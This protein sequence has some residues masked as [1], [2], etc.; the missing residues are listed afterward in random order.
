MKILVLGGTVFVGRHIVEK[1]LLLGHEVT[2]FHRGQSG[3]NLPGVSHILGNRDGG[4]D[5]LGNERWDWV[6]DTCGYVPRIV[7]QSC[8][9]LKDRGDRYLFISTISVYA[10]FVEPGLT[11]TSPL[12]TLA[13]DTVEEITGET[14]GGLKVLCEEVVTRS[15][16]ERGLIVRPGMIVGPYD[17]TDRFTF[18]FQRASKGGKMISLC[19]R[20]EPVQFIDG[21]DLAD[22]CMH[23]LGVNQVGVYNATGPEFTMTWGDVFDEA[24]LQAGV[25]YEIVRPAMEWLKEKGVDSL[26]AQYPSE[27]GLAGLYQVNVV[28]GIAAGL[29]YLPLADSVGD[30]IAWRQMVS[31]PL[32]VGLSPEKEAQLL[33]HYGQA[34]I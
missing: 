9:A 12:A 27:M 23:L 21:R 3:V 6:I 17:R 26:P 5:V 7:K 10:S 32:K 16:G 34:E 18:W 14:Y 8:D 11:E 13:D 15:F 20:D 4:L 19:E 31:E 25:E 1:A 28:E 29:K 24:A 22:F 30:T 33:A 2:V